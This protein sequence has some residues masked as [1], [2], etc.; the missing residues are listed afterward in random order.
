MLARFY[1]SMA[2]T[3]YPNTDIRYDRTINSRAAAANTRHRQ[4]RASTG[5]SGPPDVPAPHRLSDSLD[6]T[7]RANCPWGHEK[8]RRVATGRIALALPRRS[9]PFWP[10]PPGQTLVYG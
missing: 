8:F 4:S 6:R 7:S 10:L 2:C 3:N 1:D 9:E 5:H